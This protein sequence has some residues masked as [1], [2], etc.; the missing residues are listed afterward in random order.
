MIKID[1]LKQDLVNVEISSFLN[2]TGTQHKNTRWIGF[3]SVEG[4][5][6]RLGY[7]YGPDVLPYLP[8]LRMHLSDVWR[9]ATGHEPLIQLWSFWTEVDE[10]DAAAERIEKEHPDDTHD[11]SELAAV[12]FP[13][14]PMIREAVDEWFAAKG[15]EPT[16]DRPWQDFR[17][18]EVNGGQ[19]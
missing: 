8:E 9:K 19:R 16:G 1:G 14:T 13:E 5:A 10:I 17:G 2:A 3:Q 15:I 6:Y 7:G 11:L 18:L 12:V 4:L